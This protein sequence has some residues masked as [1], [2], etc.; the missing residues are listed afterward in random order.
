MYL[1]AEVWNPAGGAKWQECINACDP[2]MSLGYIIESNWKT[3][4]QVQNEVSKEAIFSI[5]YSRNDGW[6]NFFHQ[7]AGKVIITAHGR[8]LIQTI[9]ITMK[10]NMDAEGSVS[11]THLR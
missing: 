9:A 6:G 7:S 2:V 1:T 8:P 4:F 11:Y 3:N 5:A 10:Y